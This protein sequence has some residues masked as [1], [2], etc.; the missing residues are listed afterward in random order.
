MRCTSELNP[1]VIIP[2]DYRPDID[3]LR[4]LAVI[5]VMLFHFDI[6]LFAGGFV[7]VDV[8]FV[9]SGYLITRNIQRQRGNG[10]WSP[11]Q[12]FIRRCRRLLPACIFVILLCLVLG[13][14]LF[15]K[16]LFLSAAKSAISATLLIPN[17]YFWNDS[18]YF[19]TQG[20]FKP[21]LHLWSLG[22]EEQFYLIWPA[23]LIPLLALGSTARLLAVLC[24]VLA[25]ILLAELW[26]T[27]DKN[28]AYYLVPFRSTGLAV[29]ALLVFLPLLE[30]KR[31]LVADVLWLLG[32]LLVL[33]G[34]TCFSVVTDYPGIN[35]A[36]PVCGAALLIYSGRVAR[37]SRIFTLKPVVLLGLCSYSLYLIHW[38][39]AVFYRAWWFETIDFY[40]AILLSLFSISVA[41][42]MYY[43]IEKPSRL[44]G[45]QSNGSFL[46]LN[47]SLVVLIALGSSAIW[48]FEDI[49]GR[50]PDIRG[51]MV[52][53]GDFRYAQTTCRSPRDGSPG[54]F[55]GKK[56]PGKED[57]LLVGD[58]FAKALSHGLDK[59]GSQ[60]G[61]KIRLWW[62][63][64]CP[65]LLSAKFRNH[66]F[67]DVRLSNNC[68]EVLRSQHDFFKNSTPPFVMFV[69]RWSRY[70]EPIGNAGLVMPMLHK[71]LGIDPVERQRAVF[72]KAIQKNIR[73]SMHQGSR[74]IIITEPPGMSKN[75]RY[76]WAVPDYLV[77]DNFLLSRCIKNGY[78]EHMQKSKYTNSILQGLASDD[79][80]VL[81]LTDVFCNHNK[82]RCRT[83]NK[84]RFMYGDRYHLDYVG[85]QFAMKKLRRK[86]LKFIGR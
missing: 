81:S 1:R 11:W 65:A 3:G 84:E 41:I 45:L 63:P 39:A 7:G 53:Q 37:V 75:Q 80:L 40:A 54:C 66:Q 6:S 2:T 50:V 49:P 36:I 52:G 82:N 67:E 27:I 58:S 33:V 78:E 28:A 21:L 12:F 38:P 73:M 71:Q 13:F 42:A 74:A 57:I 61:L 5:C 24:V 77:S 14:L 9:I 46:L 70:V 23:V 31:V 56:R 35:V 76:C 68:K 60:N 19:A 44:A 8:F 25:S 51:F 83:R 10:D 69:S 55:L 59:L 34:A 62:E 47:G 79:V 15:S 85:S 20:A 64:N 72:E 48:Y 18:G 16:P 22:V 29:G 4:A 86:M 26:L 17:V 43:W 32:V 30:K